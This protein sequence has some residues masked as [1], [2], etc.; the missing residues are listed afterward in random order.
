VNGLRHEQL[1]L[2]ETLASPQKFIVTAMKT[3]ANRIAE[4]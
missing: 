1:R 4:L 3:T 2:A